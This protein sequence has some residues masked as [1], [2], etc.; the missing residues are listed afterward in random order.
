MCGFKRGRA[1]PAGP[2][3]AHPRTHSTPSPRGCAGARP[4][5]REPEL[6]LGAPSHARLPASH[7]GRG[8]ATKSAFCVDFNKI[9]KVFRFFCKQCWNS[10]QAGITSV[11]R[12]GRTLCNSKLSSRQGWPDG[13]YLGAAPERDSQ[14]EPLPQKSRR[15]PS[16]AGPSAT[17]TLF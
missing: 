4:G 2:T 6:G 15:R 1:P 16:P 9:A 14:A 12:K 3:R 5:R 7:A 8:K 10:I 11:G 17:L 13:V